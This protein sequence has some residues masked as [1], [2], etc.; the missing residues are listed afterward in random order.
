MDDKS[1]IWFINTHAECD[2]SNHHA[3]SVKKSALVGFPLLVFHPRV[4][5]QRIYAIFPQIPCYSLGLI[6]RG[7]INDPRFVHMLTEDKLSH[8]IQIALTLLIHSVANIR[9]IKTSHK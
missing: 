6:P 5:N 8:L 1:H 7:A 4:I 9:T 3:G 2:G